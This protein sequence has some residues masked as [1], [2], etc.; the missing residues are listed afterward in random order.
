MKNILF[1]LFILFSFISISQK[2]IKNDT[3]EICFPSKVGKQILIDLNELDKLRTTDKLTKTEIVEL[4]KKVVK[5]DSMIS[6][7]EQ[8][9]VNNLL[10]VK[11]VEEKFKLVEEDNK[12]LR[13]RIKTLGIK[14]N[15][16]EIVTG[17]I[18]SSIIYIQIFK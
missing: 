3:N 18:M 4:E 10:I 9:D 2:E 5:Q 14:N 7:L 13:G 11:S 16:I 12:D 15:I 6:K 1:L 17:V 8:K